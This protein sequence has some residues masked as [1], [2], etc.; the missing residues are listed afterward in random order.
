MNQM[1]LSECQNVLDKLPQ[2]EKCCFTE[3]ECECQIHLVLVLLG[4]VG[5]GCCRGQ[6]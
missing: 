6:G 2:K 5:P 3:N 4:N 1:S